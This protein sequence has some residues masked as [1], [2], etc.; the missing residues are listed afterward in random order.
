LGALLKRYFLAEMSGGSAAPSS[1][2]KEERGVD[3]GE[4]L[5]RNLADLLDFVLMVETVMVLSL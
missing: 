4:R 1:A 3:C 5:K 2:P